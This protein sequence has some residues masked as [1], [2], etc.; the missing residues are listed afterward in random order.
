MTE[1]KTEIRIKYLENM[2]D[3]HYKT[4]LRM[5]E[6]MEESFKTLLED[7]DKKDQ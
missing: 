3:H 6:I 1:E 2:V 4:I 7:K 5:L